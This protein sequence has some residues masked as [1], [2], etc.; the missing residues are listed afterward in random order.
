MASISN[1]QFSA[2]KSAGDDRAWVVEVRY[3]ASFLADELSKKYQFSDH[4]ELYDDDPSFDDYLASGGNISFV[5]TTSPVK[6]VITI[7]T[8]ET[9]LDTDVG[10]EELYVIVFLKNQTTGEEVNRKSDKILSLPV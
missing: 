2:K 8:T 3:D 6:R 5:P 7:D 10:N 4:C 9:T 1:I